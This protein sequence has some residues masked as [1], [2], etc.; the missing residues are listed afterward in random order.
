MRPL[1]PRFPD[2]VWDCTPAAAAGQFLGGRHA[3]RPRVAR[4]YL[5]TT[6]D[7]GCERFHE[8]WQERMA[9]YA[10]ELSGRKWVD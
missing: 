6:T 8:K 4:P 3:A 5:G 7:W 10:V 1:A 9:R 2:G